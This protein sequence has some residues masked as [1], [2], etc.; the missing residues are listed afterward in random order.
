MPATATT[1]TRAAPPRSYSRTNMVYINGGDDYRDDGRG[2]GQELTR[3]GAKN[4]VYLE[5]LPQY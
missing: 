4:F 2:N 1:E 5:N 3:T